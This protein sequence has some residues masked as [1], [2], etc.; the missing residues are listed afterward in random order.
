MGDRYVRAGCV[1]AG[2]Y[3][4]SSPDAFSASENL[5]RLSWSWC[6]LGDASHLKVAHSLPRI[7]AFVVPQSDL[8]Q[9]HQGMALV[10]SWDYFNAKGTPEFEAKQKGGGS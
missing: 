9:Y 2:V 1:P 6:K 8:Q 7:K 10:L 3:L 5:A 4:T